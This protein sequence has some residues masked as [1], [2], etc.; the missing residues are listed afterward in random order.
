MRKYALS[1][2]VAL[3]VIA[4][5]FVLTAAQDSETLTGEPIDISCYLKGQSGPGHAGCATT[6]VTERGLPAGF[7]V[8]DGD[9]TQI[10][11]VLAGQ[12]TTIKELFGDAMGQQVKATGK[13]TT[14]EGMKVFTVDKVEG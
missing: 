7:V 2:V 13:V 12:G 14:K 8:K 3:A 10:Y 11:L 5:P 6:C 4:M 9:K 1:A